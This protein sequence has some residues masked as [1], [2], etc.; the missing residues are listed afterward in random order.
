MLEGKFKKKNF[1]VVFKEFLL[2]KFLKHSQI[3]KEEG[4][5]DLNGQGF[6]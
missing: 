1:F 3:R 5:R 4:R 2:K 6:E